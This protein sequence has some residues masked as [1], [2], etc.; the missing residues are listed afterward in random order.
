MRE[1]E[2]ARPPTVDRGI[3][4]A[5]DSPSTDAAHGRLGEGMFEHVERAVA[6]THRQIEPLAGLAVGDGEGHVAVGRVPEQADV[7]AVADATVE[8]IRSP[9]RVRD[10]RLLPRRRRPPVG[11]RIAQAVDEPAGATGPIASP[12]T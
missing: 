6:V 11:D 2:A 12:R 8:R 10:R 7:D 3:R 1:A 4:Q 9:A 5:R